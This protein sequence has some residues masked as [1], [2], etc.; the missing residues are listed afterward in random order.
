VIGRALP[1]AA[2]S[3]VLVTLLIVACRVELRF[4]DLTCAQDPDC[5]VPSLHCA[6]GA[7]V[8]CATDQHCTAPGLPRCDTAKHR[9]VECG[10]PGD[11]VA[12]KTCHAGRCVVSCST[13]ATCPATTPKCD[14]GTCT[15]CDDGVGCASSTVGKVCVAHFCAACGTDANCSAATPRCDAVT[16]KCVQC[17]GNV[18]CPTATPLCDLAA[19]SCVVAP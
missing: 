1:R 10:L 13:P 7:C 14:D 8:A 11:C 5:L 17:Q 2:R 18:D 3:V 19:G 6:A 12:G 15:E 4:D 16:H 9:C